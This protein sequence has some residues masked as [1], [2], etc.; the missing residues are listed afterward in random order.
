MTQR[1]GNCLVQ[2]RGH[3]PRL[4]HGVHHTG[5]RVDVAAEMSR[6]GGTMAAMTENADTVLREAL[7]LPAAQRAQVAAD[8]IASLDEERDDAEAVAAAWA[9]ELERR[10]RQ[11]LRDPSSGEDWDTARQ[12]I[13]GRLNSG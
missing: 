13:A 1:V 12:R 8:L 5:D 11:T 2:H 7:A 3:A 10:A 9:E 6:P 4:L